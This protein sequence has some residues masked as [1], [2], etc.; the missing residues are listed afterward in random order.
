MSEFK[1][2][3]LPSQEGKIAIVTGANIGLGYETTKAFASKNIE[4]IMACR[5]ES[6]AKKAKQ[7]I[8]SVLPNAKLKVMHLDLNSNASVRTFASKFRETYTRLDI[9]VNNAGIMMPP[10]FKTKEGFESQ[11]GVNYLSHFLLTSLLFPVL[12]NTEG[13]RV[14]SLASIAHS[15]GDIYFDHYMADPSVY[16][17]RK[18]YG[19][20]KLACLMF[21]YE[22]DRQLKKRGSKVM[23]IPV[24][25]G[26]SLT[27]LDRYIP[28]FI[29][30]FIGFLG[31]VSKPEQGA[32]STIFA[33]LAS[34][35]KSGTY[36]GPTG[37]KEF[38]GPVGQVDSDDNSKDTQ[39]ALKLWQVSEELL[40]I[41][42][43]GNQ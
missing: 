38:K 13:S 11:F 19:Q 1:L 20:S 42:F 14:I 15:W 22:L 7:E 30:K 12:D 18:A 21:G 32:E 4:V 35:A 43:F 6:K 25:P 29:S 27:N 33:S 23:S 5:N 26:G 39:K 31:M 28:K 34:E 10:L 41:S 36:Y 40:D 2:K 3:D 17:K 24:H 9:L 16:N 37:F 8:L